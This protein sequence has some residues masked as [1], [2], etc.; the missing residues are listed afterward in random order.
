MF[1]RYFRDCS[2]IFVRF[3]PTIIRR[4][5]SNDTD[6]TS[7][8]S[9]DDNSFVDEIIREGNL[10]KITVTS[11]YNQTAVEQFAQ[12]VEEIFLSKF[13]STIFMSLF[14]LRFDCHL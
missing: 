2:L 13:L 3:Q 12:K 9:G 11:F 8:K 10:S 4:V 5:K 6:T 7:R 14:R 1:S